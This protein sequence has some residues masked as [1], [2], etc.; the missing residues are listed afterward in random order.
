VLF[1]SMR[2]QPSVTGKAM[3]RESLSRLFS[4]VHRGHL[5]FVPSHRSLLWRT[6]A[7][8]R[9]SF[10]IYATART[11]RRVSDALEPK[12]SGVLRDQT[13]LRCPLG[14]GLVAYRV[15]IETCLAH[16]DRLVDVA[17]IDHDPVTHHSGQLRR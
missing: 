16:G 10:E 2:D 9:P 5:E 17:Q 6:P 1:L 11:D 7:V 14:S 15:I 12:K 4:T 3:R 8:G 13:S